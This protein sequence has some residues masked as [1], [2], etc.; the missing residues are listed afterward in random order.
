LKHTQKRDLDKRRNDK[1]QQQQIRKT[2]KLTSFKETD[3]SEWGKG[4]D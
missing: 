3:R 1:Q 2:I 4:R